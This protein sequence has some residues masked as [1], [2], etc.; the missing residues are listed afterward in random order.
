MSSVMKKY[1]FW[2]GRAILLPH[3]VCPHAGCSV[4]GAQTAAEYLLLC[5]L[6]DTIPPESWVLVQAE[7]RPP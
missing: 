5:V 6:R 3:C 4:L 1:E 2:T 7:Q